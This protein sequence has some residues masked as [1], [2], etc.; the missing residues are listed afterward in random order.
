MLRRGSGDRADE[1]VSTL[2]PE[3][4]GRHSRRLVSVTRAGPTGAGEGLGIS[5]R[6][7]LACFVGVGSQDEPGQDGPG[8]LGL[9]RVSELLGRDWTA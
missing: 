2:R 3:L 4:L 6:T 5:M 7:R 8:H 9:T 1:E